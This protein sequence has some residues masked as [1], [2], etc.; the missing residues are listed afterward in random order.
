MDITFDSTTQY[1]EFKQIYLDKMEI[2]YVYKGSSS[3]T[4]TIDPSD[5]PQELREY[6]YL[7]GLDY[8]FDVV[9]LV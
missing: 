8:I 3:P 6:Y 7:N 2:I 9:P 1:L 4:Y 5:T